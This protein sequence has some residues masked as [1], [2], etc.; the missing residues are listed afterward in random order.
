[1]DELKINVAEKSSANYNSKSSLFR[2]ARYSNA[3]RKKDQEEI[4]TIARL[5]Q[6]IHG[7]IRFGKP[8]P[9]DLEA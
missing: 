8:F 5:S 9:P 1:M 4:D 2:Q 7:A 3:G 6:E